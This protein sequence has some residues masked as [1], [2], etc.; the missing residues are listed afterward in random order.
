MTLHQFD[1]IER[2]ESANENRCGG[3]GGLTD[4]V[5]HEVR[6]VVEKN[7]RVAAGEIHGAN[8]RRGTAEVMTSGIAGRVCFRF[9]NAAAEASTREIVDDHFADEEAGE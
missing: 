5:E 3:P 9:D 6:A 7:V 1:A 8:A 4:D 2:L